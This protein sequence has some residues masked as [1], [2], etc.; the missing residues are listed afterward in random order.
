MGMYTGV[1]LSITMQIIAFDLKSSKLPAKAPITTGMKLL[2]APLSNLATKPLIDDKKD[3]LKLVLEHIPKAKIP[4]WC[5][6]T[7]NGENYVIQLG[8]VSKACSKDPKGF[9]LEIA[10]LPTDATPKAIQ[11]QLINI[12]KQTANNNMKRMLGTVTRCP[13]R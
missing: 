2:G 1:Q 7:P 12:V 13:F 10:G 4:S 11:Q 8:T 3:F 9:G 5:K 6:K